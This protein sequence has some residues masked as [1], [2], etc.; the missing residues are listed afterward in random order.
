M[1]AR[2]NEDV[3]GLDIAMDNTLGMGGFQSVRDL[4]GE[5]K[6]FVDFECLL[7]NHHRERFAFQQLH[8]DEVL[9]LVLLDG[10]DRADVGVIESR[11]GPGFP[12]ETF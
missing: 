10:V 9:S 6:Q 4:D 7:A 3:C 2:R 8:H 11:G 12:L 1:T 5:G